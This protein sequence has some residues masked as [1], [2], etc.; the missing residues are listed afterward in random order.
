MQVTRLALIGILGLS[1]LSVE[2]RSESWPTK[3]IRA[4]V[5]LAAGSTTDVIPRIVFEE[6]ARQ[7]GQ[8]IVVENRPGAGGTTGAAAVA[9][10]DPDGYTILANG[11]GHTI[12][13]ALYPNLGYSPSGDFAAVI[14]FGISPNVLVVPSAKGWKT[15]SEL[16]TAAKKNPGALNYSSVG[17][18]TATHL[19]VER[20]RRSAG[21]EAAHVPFKGGGEAITEVIAGRIDFF[22]GPLGLALPHIRDG[23]LAALLVNSNERSPA[24]PQVPTTSE[25]G[26]ANAEYP[27]WFGLFVPAK[28]PREIVE[29]LH[30]ETR[31]ALLQP[32]VRE[33]LVGL[34]VDP[35]LMTPREFDALVEKEIAV[36]AE[37]VKLAGIKAK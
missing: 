23:K 10:S 8:P 11:S 25:D 32:S 34:G 20:F 6:L 35:M 9:R 5:P 14:P 7:L 19:S 33:K 30:R 37:L 29:L 3:P 28:T 27:I 4:V 12:A 18:G 17:A 22:F 1:M 16:V 15:A 31:K 2:A 36:N 21:F 24:L 13:P 26:Y